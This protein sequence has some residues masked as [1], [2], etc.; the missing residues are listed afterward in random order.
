MTIQDEIQEASDIKV[1]KQVIK[2]EKAP[3]DIRDFFG[4]PWV[5]LI[6][7]ILIIIPIVLFLNWLINLLNGTFQAIMNHFSNTTTDIFDTTILY[8]EL[9]SVVFSIGTVF[10]IN[11]YLLIFFVLCAIA[12]FLVLSK[13][14]SVYVRYRKVDYGQHGDAR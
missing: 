4:K 3:F 7:F 14:Y 6:L 12:S 11:D 2:K 13:L 9:K 5:L 1:N 10:K 8:D